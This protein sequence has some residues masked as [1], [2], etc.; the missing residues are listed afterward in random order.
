MKDQEKIDRLI[1]L[2]RE[3]EKDQKD[4][5]RKIVKLCKDKDKL[6]ISIKNYDKSLIEMRKIVKKF[7]FAPISAAMDREIGQ[8]DFYYGLDDAIYILHQ[9]NKK[10][11]KIRSRFDI[12]DL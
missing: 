3:S 10:S 6:K 8:D 4:F 7:N 11:I 12:L 5:D 1:A 2:S 9:K